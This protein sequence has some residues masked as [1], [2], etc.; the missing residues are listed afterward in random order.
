MLLNIA[1][2]KPPPAIIKDEHGMVRIPYPNKTSRFVGMKGDPIIIFGLTNSDGQDI[3]SWKQD[4]PEGPYY[5]ST[6]TNKEHPW[7]CSPRLEKDGTFV[8]ADAPTKTIEIPFKCYENNDREGFANAGAISPGGTLRNDYG[9]ETVFL[10]SGAKI[11]RSELGPHGNAGRWINITYPDGSSRARVIDS[12]GNS[13]FSPVVYRAGN[14]SG[15]DPYNLSL[16]GLLILSLTEKSFM[17]I[18]I[19]LTMIQAR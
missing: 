3:E 12:T 6:D 8:I 17:A 16:V 2:T 4:K 7:Y 11:E 13:F 15:A 1:E 18:T 9:T 10:P 19:I 14:A 5:L